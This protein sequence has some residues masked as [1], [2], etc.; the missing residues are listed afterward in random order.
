VIPASPSHV[1]GAGSFLPS[2]KGGEGRL[3]SLRPIAA[4]LMVAVVL[5]LAGCGKK[6]SPVAPPGEPDTFP[7]AY[8]RE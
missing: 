1:S 6:G 8:P 2:S 5:A 3:R 7:R 4:I